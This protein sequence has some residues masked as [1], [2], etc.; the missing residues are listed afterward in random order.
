MNSEGEQ[1]AYVLL[2]DDFPEQ[3]TLMTE[4]LRELGLRADSKHPQEIVDADLAEAD[5][6]LVDQRLDNW[7]ERDSLGAL[8]LQPINGLALSAVLRAHLVRLRPNRPTGIAIHSAHLDDLWGDAP[9]RP[10]HHTLARLNNL[11]WVFEKGAPDVA[12]VL[13]G[14]SAVAQAVQALPERW[15]THEPQQLR[16]LVRDLLELPEVDWADRAWRDVEECHAPL[17]ELA[18]SSHGLTFVRWLAQRILPY[19]CF[20]LDFRYL[21]ARL[22]VT[23]LSL[24]EALGSAPFAELLQPSRYRGLLSGLAGARWWR[25]GAEALLW[26]ATGGDP[27]DYER[28]HDVLREASGGAIRTAEVTEP[29]VVLDHRLEPSD[30]LAAL[31]ESVE[32]RPDDWP[33]Y[34]DQAWARIGDV[35]EHESLATLVFG[36]DRSLIAGSSRII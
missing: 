24:Q 26:D 32:L 2:V 8:A 27:F 28:L 1:G 6:L 36:E 11:E 29:V 31:S 16:G 17:H 20:L 15:P 30:E 33:P 35:R 4:G 19:P 22:R 23:P 34:A 14:V 10:G 18:A 9:P 5:L 25:A 3:Q 12:A 13:A 7:V 21:A